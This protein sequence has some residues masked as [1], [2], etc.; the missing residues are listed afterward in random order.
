M[1]GP[2]VEARWR[3]PLHSR[4]FVV[5]DDLPKGVPGWLAPAADHFVD[6]VSDRAY[7]CHFGRQSLGV[8]DVLGTWLGGDDA[9]VTLAAS[10]ASFLDTVAAEPKRRAVLACFVEPALVADDHQAN[11]RAFWQLLHALHAADAQPWPADVALDP[12]EPAWE[13]CFQGQSMFVFA[14]VPSHHRRLSRSLGDSLVLLFQPRHVFDGIEGGTPPGD[15]ARAII[16]RRVAEWDLAPPHPAMGNYG[17]T[18]NREWMQYFI[19]DDETQPLPS[20]CPF[21]P[22]GSWRGVIG[23]IED[24]AQRTPDAVALVDDA[25]CVTYAEMMDHVVAL[26]GRLAAAGAERGARVGVLVE[27]SRGS[28]IAL[29]SC[30]W[31]GCAYVPVDP[32]GPNARRADLLED[33]GVHVVLCSSHHL[34]AVPPAVDTVVLTDEP[35][36]RQ[37]SSYL[38]A[39]VGADDLAY[40]IYTSGST[41]AAKGVVVT[42]RQLASAV[43]AQQ[44]LERPRRTRSCCRYPCASTPREPA[45][46][47]P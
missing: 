3:V 45:S 32:G 26:G 18:E 30:Q 38:R 33:A 40:V 4:L 10:L 9:V 1:R 36:G 23:W 19:D 24:Q 8:G 39:E 43:F 20:R 16:R 2:E 34:G 7:P 21:A 44:V 47:G 28:V 35:A 27:R 12:E 14:A 22:D 25:G 31:A 5:G 11:E 37:Q 17:D 13:F 46:T 41:G 6:R 15:A 42:N 29:L